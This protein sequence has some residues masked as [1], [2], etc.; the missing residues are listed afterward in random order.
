MLGRIGAKKEKV[1]YYASQ[2]SALKERIFYLK[3]YKVHI[4]DDDMDLFF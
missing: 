4:G 2:F 1:D 3:S